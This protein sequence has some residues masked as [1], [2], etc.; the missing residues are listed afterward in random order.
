M[1]VCTCVDFEM[2]GLACKHVI[3]VQIYRTNQIAA[4]LIAAKIEAL[5]KIQSITLVTEDL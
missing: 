1:T 5:N 4:I 3:A 2:I